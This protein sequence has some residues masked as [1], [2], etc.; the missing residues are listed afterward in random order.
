[1]GLLHQSLPCF[2]NQL[3]LLR[4]ELAELLNVLLVFSAA[5]MLREGDSGLKLRDFVIECSRWVLGPLYPFTV[6]HHSH[7]CS[8]SARG[9][10]APRP[11][12]LGDNAE[13]IQAN[14]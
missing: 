7:P 6:N 2:S 13:T 9:C 1:M 8:S 10:S 14:P 4:L 11:S 12:S 5:P 3:L